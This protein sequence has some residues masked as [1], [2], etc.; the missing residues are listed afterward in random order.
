MSLLCDY[1]G[2]LRAAAYNVV[3]AIVASDADGVRMYEKEVCQDE[4][5][6]FFM[7]QCMAIRHIL[8]LEDVKFRNK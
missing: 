8:G 4:E 3:L 1:E 6:I 2:D 7:A 5:G